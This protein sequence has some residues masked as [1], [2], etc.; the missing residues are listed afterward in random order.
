VPEEVAVLGVDNDDVICRLCRPT[1]S[2]I[3]P[4]GEEIGRLASR[5]IADQLEGKRVELHHVVPPRRI[6]QRGSTDT[7]GADDPL[8]VRAARLIR[9]RDFGEASVEQISEAIGVSRST[10]DKLFQ[11]D[12]GRSVAGEIGRLR[13]QRSQHLLCGTDLALSEIARRCG[14]SSAT[15]FCRF[16]KRHTGRTPLG[17]R[18]S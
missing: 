6:V 16:F 7:V 4:D 1:L 3:E 9:E 5:L 13:L 8:V 14:F 15:Y 2:S 11:Q 10:L 12:L 17:F 18:R